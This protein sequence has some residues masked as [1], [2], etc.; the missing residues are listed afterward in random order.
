MRL[1]FISYLKAFRLD[2]GGFEVISTGAEPNFM[3]QC[4]FEEF[5]VE[6]PRIT[7]IEGRY[8]IT[9]VACS[10][11]MGVCT[12]L[13][14]TV[15][16][17][18]YT[19]HGII[20]PMENKDVVILPERAGDDYVAYHRPGG[21]YKFEYL[22]M[23][24]ARSKDLVHWGRHAHLMS[25]RGDAWDSHKLGGGAVPLKTRVGWLEIYHGVNNITKDDPIGAYHAGAA[26]F[27][28]ADPG[29]LLA[30]SRVPI[31]SPDSPDEKTGFVP[32]VIFPTACIY[33][34][35]PEYVLLYC[36]VAD[37]RVKV[38]KLRL[39]DIMAALE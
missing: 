35:D 13:A 39:R 2:P 28:L 12:A 22:S 17:A 3:P 4:E 10:R 8:L 21:H 33:D 25:P 19:R 5:G 11:D 20:F 29:K 9:Y 1:T 15:D 34:R 30:R 7:F 38:I 23:Q 18:H 32:N 24:C 36:G 6:D 37:E 16:F 31:L 14:E 26:L 27:D